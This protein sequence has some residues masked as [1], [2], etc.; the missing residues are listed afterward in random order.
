M[1]P[2]SFLSQILTNIHASYGEE[3]RTWTDVTEHEDGMISNEA[4]PGCETYD[5]TTYGLD[6]MGEENGEDE[7]DMGDYQDE[8][9]DKEIEDDTHSMESNLN[10]SKGV[11]KR[12]TRK[13]RRILDEHFQRTCVRTRLI[14]REDG[15]IDVRLDVRTQNLRPGKRVFNVE[16]EKRMQTILQMRAYVRDQFE[17]L[18]MEKDTAACQ[19]SRIW[20]QHPIDPSHALY[21]SHKNQYKHAFLKERKR[22][23]SKM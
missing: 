19:E 7:D 4:E 13:Q 9:L 1:T 2:P 5:S 3:H 16:K 15:C 22:I 8:N 20:E 17:R 6:S 10:A 12:V 23:A 11:T 21:S 18:S 14:L